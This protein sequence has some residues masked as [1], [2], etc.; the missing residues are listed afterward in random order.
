MPPLQQKAI[1]LTEAK[2]SFEIHTVNV[3]KPGPGQILMKIEATALNPVDYMVQE[4]G[5]WVEEFPT[6]LGCEAAGTVEELGEG[7]SGLSQGDRVYVCPRSIEIS[8]AG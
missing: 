6:I 3:S 1:F 8:Q 2:G 7:V 4:T 5:L